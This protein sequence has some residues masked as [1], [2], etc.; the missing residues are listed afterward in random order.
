M[1]HPPTHSLSLVLSLVHTQ[2][3][4]SA[5]LRVS[6]GSGLLV[7][8]SRGVSQAGKGSYGAAAA[9][10][11]ALIDEARHGAASASTITES[12]SEDKK[13]FIA[14]A[15]EQSALQFGS[16]T[17]KSGRVSPFFFNAGMF[18]SGKSLS[19]LCRY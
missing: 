8:V 19:T 15:L 4:C 14:F 12:L 13:E 9:A 3:V 1:R 7:S 16:F 10:L 18:C 2:A 17:L 6:D 5:G 11:K